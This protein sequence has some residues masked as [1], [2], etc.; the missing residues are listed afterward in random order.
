MAESQAPTDALSA[1]RQYCAAGFFPIPI[2]HREKAPK[3]AGWNEL[4]LTDQSI[5]S[6]FQNGVPK[7]IGVL[8]GIGVADTDLDCPEAIRAAEFFL[9][10]T[11][12]RFGRDSKPNSHHMYRCD[13]P[14]VTKQYKDVDGT[15]IVE[16][17]GLKED[18]SVGFQTV[19][20]PS[21]HKDTG[22]LI[23]FEP[24]CGPRPS[25]ENAELLQKHVAGIAS[26][27][28][29]ARHW[30]A[31]GGGRNPA[32][33]ALAGGLAR[34]GLKQDDTKRFCTAV[35]HS[36]DDPDPSAMGRSD[37]E[38]A[39]TY[40]NLESGEGEVTGWPRLIELLGENGAAVV[41][42]VL[43]WL[44]LAKASKSDFALARPLADVPKPLPLS[45]DMVPE[46]IL[47]RIRDVS[48]RQGS[49][50]DMNYVFC[51]A[52][53]AGM[54]NDAVRIHPKDQDDEYKLPMNIYGLTI[55]PPGVMKSPA[56]TQYLKH[57]VAIQIRR[58][59][60]YKNELMDW[61]KECAIAEKKGDDKPEKPVEHSVLGEDVTPEKL[62]MV[63]ENN[64]RGLL[65]AADEL[66]MIFED[67][68]RETRKKTRTLLK[69]GTD[70]LN[71]SDDRVGRNGTFVPRVVLST[72]GG[73]QPKV[74]QGYFRA[75]ASDGLLPRFQIVTSVRRYIRKDINRAPNAD[76]V[77]QMQNLFD[78]FEQIPMDSHKLK[79]DPVAQELYMRW[80]DDLRK[81]Q[82]DEPERSELMILYL[83]KA[84]GTVPR[85]AALFE[86]CKWADTGT[87][88][89]YITFES[90]VMAIK[91][92]AYFESQARNAYTCTMGTSQETL[93]LADLVLNKELP[94]PFSKRND[95]Y[96]KCFPGLKESKEIDQAVGEMI[97]KSVAI[98]MRSIPTSLN[99]VSIS[100]VKATPEHGI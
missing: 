25:D 70:G 17:R 9:Q 13:K 57:V 2:G 58:R 11:D 95:I 26:A 40:K 15:M 62:A 51:L 54:I 12:M 38:V 82:S 98:Y 55:A 16:L 80:L 75:L 87:G 18:G 36:L 76:A 41:T 5:A 79:F 6:Y 81:R 24:G 49:P 29:L 1:A 7:N 45:D 20:P 86:L 42:K 21:V 63:L 28:L 35:Y 39:C 30:P 69:K 50:I 32:M 78:R 72:I 73:I 84:D 96:R 59:E 65:L 53:L 22:E 94:S 91:A 60:Q 88:T 31:K 99:R 4:R 14:V 97:R 34:A 37:T 43:D 3:Y 8:L 92:M 56:L 83:A 27:A 66:E 33:L 74:I 93:I 44:G 64:P 77:K 52:C 71:H 89:G 100:L 85:L 67:L 90:T 47:P 23:R 19:V 10:H 48:E 46:S 68:E 61:A